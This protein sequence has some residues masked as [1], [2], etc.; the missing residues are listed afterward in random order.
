MY[1]WSKDN[2]SLANPYFPET[3]FLLQNNRE[4]WV[5]SSM[6]SKRHKGYGSGK[7]R[8]KKQKVSHRRFQVITVQ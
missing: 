5:C 1:C 3:D 6:D 2:T 8:Q 4:L 7:Q